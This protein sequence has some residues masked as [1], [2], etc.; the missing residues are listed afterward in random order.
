MTQL[1][2]ACNCLALSFAEIL[3]PA[4]QEEHADEA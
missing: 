2:A 3:A 1:D 4:T